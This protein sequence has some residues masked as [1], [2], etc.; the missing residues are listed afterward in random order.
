MKTRFAGSVLVMSAVFAMFAS[1]QPSLAAVP[2]ADAAAAAADDTVSPTTTKTMTVSTTG[3]AEGRGHFQKMAMNPYMMIPQLIALG[4]APIVLANLKM[5]VMSALMM[6]NMALNAA[7]FMT[8]RNMV[9]GPRPKVKYVNY[10]YRDHPHHHHHYGGDT[11]HHHHHAGDGH[12]RQQH[13]DEQLLQT[14][15]DGIETYERRKRTAVSS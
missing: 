15:V 4:F 11:S 12:L 9:F 3:V 6:N 8:I 7:I 10:G 5:M 14:S 13:Q 1:V 2:A